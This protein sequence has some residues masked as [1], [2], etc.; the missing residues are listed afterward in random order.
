MKRKFNVQNLLF[1]LNSCEM[2]IV[3]VLFWKNRFRIAWV[4]LCLTIPYLLKDDNPCEVL[5]DGNYPIR[6][7]F[8]YMTCKDKKTTYN[9]CEEKEV[10][11]PGTL[12]CVDAS[13]QSKENFCQNR[14]NGDWLDPWDCH[15]FFKCFY[16]QAYE[17][18]CQTKE[19]VY[20]PNTDACVYSKQYECKQLKQQQ[21]LLSS[22]SFYEHS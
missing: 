7:V 14:T 2:R 8:K 9:E 10:F 22:E 3:C 4:L 21:K 18:Q 1:H 13:T 15:Q 5:K 12:V 16:K 17:Y 20:N 6:D 19:L 11:E